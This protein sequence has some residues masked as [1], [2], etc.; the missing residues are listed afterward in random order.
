MLSD[1]SAPPP[2]APP[3]VFLCTPVTLA[4]GCDRPYHSVTSNTTL[5]LV[6][7][8][9]MFSWY[10]G[11]LGTVFV[12][13]HDKGIIRGLILPWRGPIL[14]LFT[15]PSGLAPF[16]T[17]AKFHDI[18]MYSRPKVSGI[19]KSLIRGLPRPHK[20]TYRVCGRALPVEWGWGMVLEIGPVSGCRCRLL[21][22]VGS[23]PGEGLPLLGSVL[24][25][26]GRSL[27]DIVGFSRLPSSRD[28]SRGPGSSRSCSFCLVCAV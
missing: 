11:V 1:S 3:S 26:F 6:W 27:F 7:P 20:Q 8:W 15:L 17:K 25:D 13:G 16:E 12:I 23:I 4:S 19:H 10:R 9:P 14:P 24:A 21:H 18:A 5:S 28:R 2:P 22:Q